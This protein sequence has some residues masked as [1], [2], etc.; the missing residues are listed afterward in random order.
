MLMQFSGFGKGPLSDHFCC[1]SSLLTVRFVSG[2]SRR[3]IRA[4]DPRAGGSWDQASPPC[5]TN[6]EYSPVIY[7]TT[8]ISQEWLYLQEAPE[9]R[10]NDTV[11][12][13]VS[14]CTGIHLYLFLIKIHC[15]TWEKI[16]IILF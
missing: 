3:T 1:P 8:G 2:A 6:L 4:K 14:V 7:C 10:G 5:G 15:G 13:P 11:I 9:T 16:K 12:I